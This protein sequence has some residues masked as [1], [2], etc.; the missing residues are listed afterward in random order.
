MEDLWYS[1]THRWYV[2]LFLVAF[3]IYGTLEHGVRRTLFW[4]VSGYTIAFGAEWMSIHHH[5]P[6]GNYQYNYGALHN[7]LVIAGVPFFDSLSFAFL[8]YVAFSFAQFFVAPLVRRGLDVQ[9]LSTRKIR[10]GAT[11]LVL[12]AFLMLVIDWVTDP[13]TVL[14]KYWFLGDI[15]YYPKPGYHFGITMNNYYGW[16]LTGIAVIF[17]NQRFDAWLSRRERA[18]SAAPRLRHVPLLGLVAPLFW[19]GIVLFQLG[20]TAWL[21][22]S[23]DLGGVPVDGRTAFTDH[24]R[25]VL[26]SGCFIIAPILLLAWVTLTRGSGEPGTEEIEAW[27]ADYPQSEFAA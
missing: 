18:G 27:K 25:T 19:A 26:I 11:V 15:Y 8:S 17:V 20:I 12:G 22:W 3:L 1:M 24:A 21:A 5:Y 13:V 7:D 6:M 14:G 23:Y 16:F 10:N 2:T 4:L 9:R